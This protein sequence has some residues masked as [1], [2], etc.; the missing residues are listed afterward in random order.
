MTHLLMQEISEIKDYIAKQVVLSKDI[1]TFKEAVLY[2]GIP[3]STLYKLTSSRN[4]PFYKPVSKSIFFNRNELDTWLLKNR[5][6]TKNELAD[7]A[8][9]KCK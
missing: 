4:I 5:Y 3:K 7:I 9:T 2:T 6:A 1:M 8:Y